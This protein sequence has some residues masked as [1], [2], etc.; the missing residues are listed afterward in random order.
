MRALL[1]V[2]TLYVNAGCV[3]ANWDLPIIYCFLE[4]VAGNWESAG[5]LIWACVAV[6]ETFSANVIFIEEI[7][8]SVCTGD[9]GALVKKRV[10]LAFFAF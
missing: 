4:E 5:V 3:A 6:G 8:Y 9:A 1:A 10:G 2:D 7:A